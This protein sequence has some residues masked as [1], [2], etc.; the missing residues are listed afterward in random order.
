MSP[1]RPRPHLC[2]TASRTRLKWEEEQ[3]P[4][5]TEEVKARIPLEFLKGLEQ[6]DGVDEQ[7]T[8]P[9]AILSPDTKF[10]KAVG[11]TLPWSLDALAFSA[12]L[13]S[14]WAEVAENADERRRRGDLVRSVAG[15]DAYGLLT[16]CT[17]ESTRMS[18]S[19]FC[20]GG[21]FT[22]CGFTTRSQILY[23]KMV[24]SRVTPPWHLS[25]ARARR[26]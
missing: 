22:L 12:W 9:E 20:T 8:L 4:W 15:T 1:P 25:R 18:P 21:C 11:D 14:N 13:E 6:R 7:I 2:V 16:G 23:L 5:F 26:G 24:E 10:R 3:P 19:E 17:T